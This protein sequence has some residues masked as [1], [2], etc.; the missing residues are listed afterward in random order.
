MNKSAGFTL[1]E[2]LIAVSLASVVMMGMM[3]AYRNVA[4]HLENARQMLNINRKVCLLCNQLE[5]DI[6]TAFIPPYY[7]T[8]KGEGEEKEKEDKENKEKSGEQK[9][10]AEKKPQSPEDAKKQEEKEQQELKNFFLAAI[11]ENADFMRVE[12]KKAELFKSLTV[13]NTNPLQVFGQR[14]MR[15]VR[16]MYA[17]VVDKEKSKD[18][19]PSYQ[20]WRKETTDLQNAQL[21]EPEDGAAAKDQNQAI[22]KH[23]VADNL[24]A[25]VVEY[26]LRKEKKEEPGQK[27][28]NKSFEE[29]TF[30]TWGDRKETMGVVPVR[31]LVKCEFWND[32]KTEHYMF[33]VNYPVFSFPTIKEKD[34]PSKMQKDKDKGKPGEGQNPIDGKDQTTVGQADATNLGEEAQPGGPGLLP[35]P[36]APEVGVEALL[37]GGIT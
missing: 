20:L 1:L 11:N 9:P 19:A 37:G 23:L 27:K 15:I 34:K 17:L 21:K 2:V 10:V 36:G 8:K 35:A 28:G 14:R 3:Q 22:R 5:R 16:V 30:F 4:M 29:K 33:H 25:F 24:K 12:G 32:Q 7:K 31:V 18:G 13:I 26:V 6:T